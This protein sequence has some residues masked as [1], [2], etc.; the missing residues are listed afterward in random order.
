MECNKV[1]KEA[2]T[3]TSQS[4]AARIMLTPHW[5]E[6]LFET[7]WAATSTSLSWAM[8]Y[9]TGKAS[10]RGILITS[11]AHLW[12]NIRRGWRKFSS[13]TKFEVKNGSKIR[14]WHYL[15]C[16]NIALKETFSIACAKDA[17]ITTHWELF[18]IPIN[19]IWALLEVD[20]FTSMM[21]YST[22]VRRKSENKM[23]WSPPKEGLFD[24]RSF[25]SALAYREGFR[26]RFPWKS[27]WR[28]KVPLRVAFFA[29]LAAQRRILIIDNLRKRHAIMVNRFCMFKRNGE[30]MDHLLFYCEVAY[31]IWNVFSNRFRLS[32]V[33]PRQHSECWCVEDNVFV[34][35]MVSMNGNEW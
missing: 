16:G 18:L 5:K 10:L 6:P 20:V 11:Y 28:T 32:W 17:S 19:G 13:H 12:K 8:S 2:T 9:K 25:Y 1:M 27:F 4:W 3:S 7:K 29:W 15:W 35:F 24:D 14:F 33:M 34:S 30:T 23:W 26:F 22:R 21:F 31:V